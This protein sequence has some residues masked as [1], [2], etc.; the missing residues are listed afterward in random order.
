[1]IELTDPFEQI[2][3]VN[4][5]NKYKTAGMIATRAVDEVVKAA[6]PGIKL[7]ELCNI[8]N[9]LIK[10]E[11]D[12]VYKDIKYKGIAF[13]ICLSLNNIAGH[14]IP[15]E[16]DSIKEGDL[17]KIELGV[18]IDGFP[19][20]ITFT[21]LITN[22]KISDKRS[23]VMKAVIEASKEIY[24]IMKP[25]NTS[26][27]VVNVLNK[28][29]TKYNCNLPVCNDKGFVPGVLSC[30]V[31]RYIVDGYDDDGDEYIHRFIM[32]KDNPN[33]EFSSIENELEDGE[34]YAIDI[35]MST[36]TGKLQSI[37]RTDI[38]KRDYETR[39]ELKLK[40]SKEALSK[41]NK[42]RFP[43]SLVNRDAKTKIGLKEC[44]DKNLVKTY[45]VVSDKEGEYIARVKFTVIVKDKPILVCGKPSDGELSKLG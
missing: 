43:I 13:P 39:V 28:Y 11:C 24:N 9:N 29:A 3:D 6:K 7:N 16:T 40:S 37:D 2:K 12:K 1:M 32:A 22:N 34:V 21:T 14:Y 35:M 23:N 10:I 33:L 42:E 25:G 8:A 30:Q 44:I 17:L 4:N 18:H 5:V 19:A 20:L 38:Y 31:S 15:N 41:F 27:D 45:P 36:G 26:K